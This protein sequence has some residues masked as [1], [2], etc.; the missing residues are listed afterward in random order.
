VIES[1][2]T[3]ADVRGKGMERTMPGKGMERTVIDKGTQKK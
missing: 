2:K 3:G 1:C